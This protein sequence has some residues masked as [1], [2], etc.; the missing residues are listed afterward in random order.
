MLVV[1]SAGVAAQA[2]EVLLLDWE[3]AIGPVS[4]EYLRDGLAEAADAGAE[5]LVFRMDTPGGLDTAMREM[6]RDIMA[7]PVP[8]AVY[9]APEG[10][11]A[12]SAGVFLI[13]AA[14]VAA[15]APATN[16]GAAHPVGVGGKL[17]ET[18]AEKV[19]NDA[20]AYLRSLAAQRGR[21]QEWSERVVHR[22]VSV[23]ADSALALG[24]IDHVAA[25]L[26]DLQEQCDGRVVTTA[27]GERTLQTA[28]A[29]VVVR[30]LSWRQEFLRRITDPN[31]AYIFMMLGVYGLFFELSRPGAIVPGVVGAICLLLALL[32]FQGLPV[33][34]V[35]VLLI[36]VGMV[37]L[38][39]EIKI[40]SFG[41]L[42]IGGTVSLLLGSLLLFENA[43]PLARLSLRVVL[44][45]VIFTVVFFLAIV[46]MAMRAQ[47]RRRVTGIDA[48]VGEEAEVR[49]AEAD[50]RSGTVA[51][52]GELWRYA[53]DVPLRRGDR[54][55]VSGCDGRRVIVK[56]LSA[57]VDTTTEGRT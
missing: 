23:A 47:R 1:A 57:D 31:I 52:F 45:V 36:L 48:L 21:N 14:H 49:V 34:Y 25:D 32:A 29:A 41:T 10:A 46:G 24:V 5:L 15:M 33:N 4:A 44:P 27:A 9:V 38:L 28:G 17:D 3:G 20:A 43:G 37:L 53:A 55:V 39:L 16:V 22:S 7:S 51:V 8:V 18:M 56:P 42:A 54:V 26:D 30:D 6:I 12:A 40:T 13:T 50:G 35:G 19:A 2:G 11:R